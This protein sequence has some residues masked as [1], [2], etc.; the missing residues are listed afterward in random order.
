MG[1]P[2][3]SIAF[4]DWL[5]NPAL[6]TPPQ[7]RSFSQ[8]VR[9]IEHTFVQGCAKKAGL[10]HASAKKSHCDLCASFCEESRTCVVEYPSQT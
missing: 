7:L 1:T 10:A 8:H 2:V 5:R 4:A 9:M 3:P 6:P